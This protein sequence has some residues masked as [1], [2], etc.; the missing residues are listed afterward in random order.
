[1]SGGK[2]KGV[3]CG[4][5]AKR[6]RVDTYPK[7]VIERAASASHEAASL[8]SGLLRDE[9]YAAMKSKASELSILLDRLVGDY[10]EDKS[11]KE[12]DTKLAKLNSRYTKGEDEIDLLRSQLSSASDLQITRIDGAID[13]ARGEVAGLLAEMGGKAKTDMLDLAE[14]DT[15]LKLIKLLQGPVRRVL[16]IHEV[17]AADVEADAAADDDVEADAADD[18]DVE[19]GDDDVEADDDE[20][21]DEEIED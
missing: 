11:K 17:S 21:G 13:G 16:E 4:T 20:D 15:N 19:V 3:V 9:A 18:N 2:G 12:Y 7:A 10:D 6:E 5:P 8:V 1:M 14:I